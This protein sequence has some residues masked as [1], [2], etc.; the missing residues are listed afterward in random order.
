MRDIPFWKFMRFRIAHLCSWFPITLDLPD[1]AHLRTCVI[2]KVLVR[3][4][5]F[6]LS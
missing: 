6:F 3:K 4:K 2:S 5:M 1:F